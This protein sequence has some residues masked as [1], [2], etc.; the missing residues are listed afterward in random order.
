MGKRI[1]PVNSEPLCFV[2]VQYNEIVNMIDLHVEVMAFKIS[3]YLHVIEGCWANEKYHTRRSNKVNSARRNQTL[4]VVQ[5]FIKRLDVINPC[6]PAS[7]S[8]ERLE[9]CTNAP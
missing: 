5:K 7:E 9:L 2:V 3:N 4:F 8:R 1:I 6:K